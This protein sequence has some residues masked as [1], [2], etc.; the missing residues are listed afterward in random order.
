M[1]PSS[2]HFHLS[3][4]LGSLVHGWER[5]F[6]LLADNVS[7]A[8]PLH[9]RVPQL[10]WRGRVSPDARDELRRQ[11]VECPEVRHNPLTPLQEAHEVCSQALWGVSA[12]KEAHG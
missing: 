8:L 2:Y 6:K 7:A 11:F 3:G 9:Q 4:G 5:Q 10:M 12:S 1:K